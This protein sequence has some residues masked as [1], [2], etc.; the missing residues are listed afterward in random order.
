MTDA[1]KEIRALAEK[2]LTA[3]DGAV[4]VR[5]EGICYVSVRGADLKNLNETDLIVVQDDS[6]VSPD[7]MPKE[8]FLYLALFERF[9]HINVL[10][11]T[12]TESVLTASIVGRKIRP[13][14]DD[15]AQIVGVSVRC[16]DEDVFGDARK[17]VNATSAM[18][19]RTALMIR[20]QGA[21]CAGP[22]FDD[23]EVSAVVFEKACKTVIETS[24]L[25]G[26]YYIN[27]IECWLMHKVYQLK[28]SKQA[29]K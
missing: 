15:M 22:T 6:D 29:K 25:G 19:D 27:P 17:I 7:V 21:I 8:Y 26:G 23:A 11:R 18:K 2:G 20:R 10:F 28:Y 1:V 24:F 4:A 16:A 14:L 5:K 13:M 12:A 9:P 3:P